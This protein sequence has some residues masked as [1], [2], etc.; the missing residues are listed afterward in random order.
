MTV[1]GMDAEYGGA[2]G[3]VISMVSREGGARFG[4]QLEYRLQPPGVKHFGPNIYDSGWLKL[5]TGLADPWS[6]PEFS[7]THSRTDYDEKLGHWIEGSLN[8]PL[9]DNAGFFVNA[10]TDR[11]APVFPN[12]NMGPP[13]NLSAMGSVT[14]RTGG[15]MK[16][17]LGGI[18]STR[19][20]YDGDSLGQF[21]RGPFIRKRVYFGGGTNVRDASNMFLP[22]GFASHGIFTH[23]E[24]VV[25]LT[26][27]H[28]ISPTTFYD[29]RVSWQQSRSTTDVAA[30][31]NASDSPRPRDDFGF[32]TPYRVHSLLDHDRKRIT[33]KAD[34]TSQLSKHILGKAGLQLFRYDLLAWE[35]WDLRPGGTERRIRMAGKG[36]PTT[37][38][39]RSTRSR[40]GPTPR[41]R[42]SSRV[43]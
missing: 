3:G 41:R 23:G 26:A 10:K 18:Y 7:A 1:G 25:Y 19:E 32:I 36:I 4:G 35:Y 14:L 43:W 22:E 2:S 16:F 40:S 17:K 39:S 8:G 29:I 42:W 6:D 33:F 37:D 11:S 30:A 34:V 28:T 9:S 5:A 15:N 24:R 12:A 31:E 21:R 20:Q 13:D 27:T 38:G